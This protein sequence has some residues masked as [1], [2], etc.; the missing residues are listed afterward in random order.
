MNL[1]ELPALSDEDRAR[2]DHY[3]M[4]ARLFRAPPDASLLT[5]IERT[6]AGFA[7]SAGP[8]AQAWT[9]LAQAA[10]QFD[11]PSIRAEYDRLFIG[12]GRPEVFLYGSYYQAGFLM[13]EPLAVLRDDLAALG[14]ARRAGVGESEDHLA[15]LAEAMRHLIAGGAG[16][17]RQRDFY[18]RHL[19]PWVERLADVLEAAPGAGFYG[20][21]ASLCRAF[22]AIESAA[23]AMP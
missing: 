17:D 21:A 14:L 3:A 18:R 15:A 19:E 7:A 2:A 13:E 5:M 20:P 22:F 11:A 8:L 1:A 10:S 12:V 4:I 9:T 6:A 16:V 23:F